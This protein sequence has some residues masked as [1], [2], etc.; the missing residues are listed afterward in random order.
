MRKRIVS[1]VVQQGCCHKNADVLVS[2]PQRRVGDEQARHK[3]LGQV[4]N[5]QRM[6]E[7]RM[8]RSWIDQMDISELSYVAKALEVF[9]VYKRQH[10]GREVNVSPDWVADCFALVGQ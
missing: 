3:L 10:G 8:A 4:V 7:T 9:G 2:K 5:A 1:D 6:F